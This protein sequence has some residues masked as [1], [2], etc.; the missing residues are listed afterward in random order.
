MKAIF[1]GIAAELDRHMRNE[2]EIL[3]PACIA[4]EVGTID[5]STFV[6]IESPIRGML[7]SPTRSPPG[8]VASES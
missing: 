7:E 2:E 8:S 5:V 6:S 4:L 1:A 3:F